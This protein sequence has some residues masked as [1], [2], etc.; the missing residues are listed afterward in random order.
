MKIASTKNELNSALIG[1]ILFD[2]SMKNDHVLY[3]RHGGKQLSYVDEKVSYLSKYMK[4]KS[5]RTAVDNLGYTYRYAYYNDQKLKYLYHAIYRDGKKRLPS[6][7]INRFTPVTLAF[8]YMDDG[9]L[10]LHKGKTPRVY[11]SREIILNTQSFSKD[12]VKNLQKV[13]SRKY[14]VN[15][16]Y[17]TDK[18]N[19]RLW[20]N[21]SN[22]LKFLTIV[23]P[24]VKEYKCMRY[25]LDLKYKKKQISFL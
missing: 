3:L 8:M 15:F 21:T 20:C 22:T 18:G 25:K 9:C 19:P 4:P 24:I 13:L 14:G 5:C 12:E 16:K 10:A 7:I 17:T 2:G 23:A 11:K 1:M 6:N